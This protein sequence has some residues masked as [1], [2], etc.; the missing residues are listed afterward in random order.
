M[1]VASVVSV[2]DRQS[3]CHC[4]HTSDGEVQIDLFNL[5]EKSSAI[6]PFITERRFLTRVK[7]EGF[8]L[9][10]SGEASQQDTNGYRKYD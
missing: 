9:I 10:E 1:C 2:F 6:F 8:A 3:A 7:A 4:Q 5:P